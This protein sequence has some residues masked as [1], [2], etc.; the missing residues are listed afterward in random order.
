MERRYTWQS[1][2]RRD[3]STSSKEVIVGLM[4][5]TG[6]GKS[7]FIETVTG[8]RGIAGHSLDGETREVKSY[9][10]VIDGVKVTLVDTPGF[11]D[12][13]ESNM[14]IMKKISTWLASSYQDNRLLSGIVYLHPIKTPR[15]TGAAMRTL[16][17]IRSMCGEKFY[18]NL[19]LC[20]TFWDE[21]E[22]SQGFLREKELMENPGFW[23]EMVDR[24]A[25]CHRLDGRKAACVE[26]LRTILNNQPTPL[27]MNEEMASPGGIFENTAA[28]RSAGAGG[29]G[30]D[31]QA[32]KRMYEDM[33]TRARE[34]TD[35]LLKRQKE[36]HERD[37]QMEKFRMEMAFKTQIETLK[38]EKEMNDL[39][40][41]NIKTIHKEKEEMLQR[42]Q[43]DTRRNLT[44]E[45][46]RSDKIASDR[47]DELN[48][49]R[50]KKDEIERAMEATKREMREKE[51]A[52]QK[53]LKDEEA[54]GR[55]E[56]LKLQSSWTKYQIEM[57]GEV[58][59][60]TGAKM[61]IDTTLYLSLMMT[62]D[63]CCNPLGSGR[64]YC[65]AT[66]SEL[67]QPAT[68]TYDLCR[69]CYEQGRR[70]L[71]QDHTLE[72]KNVND[73]LAGVCGRAVG[74]A[75]KI[76]CNVCLEACLGMYLRKLNNLTASAAVLQYFYSAS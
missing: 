24:G 61:F 41:E 68:N 44:E 21:I 39:R 15:M 75:K 55:L 46:T 5:I 40:L 23:R 14:D 4:G 11:D 10:T 59:P 52:T 28:A 34:E 16:D 13:L 54:Y 12:N 27:R 31:I 38:M 7:T 64:Y 50:A 30:G 37:M 32:M 74:L 47:L 51:T 9:D 49:L 65:C 8:R 62:C 73:G 57:F 67:K 36:Q 72:E 35:L 25:N 1:S 45:Q 33:L 76:F 66:C 26:V 53:K 69:H 43:S 19:A 17:M 42:M 70:C 22:R 2:S 63:S 48:R 29:S 18:Q 60:A 3:E 6:A 71:S 58:G 20:T 56:R